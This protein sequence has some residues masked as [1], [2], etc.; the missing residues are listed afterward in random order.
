MS[1]DEVTHYTIGVFLP[2]NP[3]SHINFAFSN[4][5]FIQ[6]LGSLS[7]VNTKMIKVTNKLRA[8][9]EYLFIFSFR[10]RRENNVEN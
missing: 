6:Q 5:T 9:F 7:L 1:R 2:Q 4:V 3:F 10:R 8:E